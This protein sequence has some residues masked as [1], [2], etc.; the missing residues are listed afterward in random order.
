MIHNLLR[1]SSMDLQV[2]GEQI[3]GRIHPDD[4]TKISAKLKLRQTLTNIIHLKNVFLSNLQFFGTQFPN[5]QSEYISQHVP[6]PSLPP[7]PNQ[8]KKHLFNPNCWGVGITIDGG[9]PGYLS[10]LPFPYPFPSIRPGG[11]LKLGTGT[12]MVAMNFLQIPVTRRTTG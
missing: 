8:K 5:P 9:V 6:F 4:P 12:G 3:F 2:F 7:T 11:G 10:Y 1:E